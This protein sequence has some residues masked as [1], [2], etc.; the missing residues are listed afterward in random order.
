ME[1][2]LHHESDFLQ[3]FDSE[4]EL[5]EIDLVIPDAPKMYD[6]N[7]SVE[8]FE[9]YVTLPGVF[10]EGVQYYDLKDVNFI[11]NTGLINLIDLLKA[12]LK[13]G[14]ALQFV[15][16]NKRVRKKIKAMGLD[17]VLNCF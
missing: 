16:V 5:T 14:K 11:N 2:K 17:S 6:I 4:R 7:V 12:N 10:C 1:T 13:E 15:N 8:E 9:K 3:M